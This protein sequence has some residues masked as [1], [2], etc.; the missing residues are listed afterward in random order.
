MSRFNI[1][2]EKERINHAKEKLKEKINELKI[3][4]NK[5][6]QER[7]NCLKH[8]RDNHK[9]EMNDVMTKLRCERKKEYINYIIKKELERN[10]KKEK[11]KQRNQTRALSA[12]IKKQ[13]EYNKKLNVKN[14]II[15]KIE[16]EK[17]VLWV[18][19]KKGKCGQQEGMLAESGAGHK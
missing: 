15:N 6:R 1:L 3:Q 16:K 8:W 2:Q 5:S 19:K 7:D 17:D 18:R 12:E 13:E 10:L 14:D 4:N 11:I 9:E